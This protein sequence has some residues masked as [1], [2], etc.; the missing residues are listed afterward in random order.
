[1]Y[2]IKIYSA[3]QYHL[4]YNF[5]ISFQSYPCLKKDIFIKYQFLLIILN[6]SNHSLIINECY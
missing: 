1:M 4:C 3:N 2:F 5:N 6:L